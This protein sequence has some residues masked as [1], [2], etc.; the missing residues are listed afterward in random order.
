MAEILSEGVETIDLAPLAV[1]TRLVKLICV[2]GVDTKLVTVGQVLDLLVDAA[3]GSLDTLNELAAAIG[4][5]ANFA[6]TVIAALANRLR[7]DAAQTLTSDQQDRGRANLGISGRNLI[8]NGQGRVNQRGYVSGAATTGANQ[9][10]LDR[11]RV[12]TS[13][14]NLSFTG[15]DSRRVMTAPAGGAEQVV[16][17][18]AV[19]GGTYVLN[20]TG[21]A[22]ATV[23]G[24]ARAKGATFTLAAN[25]NVTIR[26]SGGTFSDVQLELAS[27]PTAY[28]RFSYARELVECQRY[29]LVG[30][31]TVR[32]QG[33]TSASDSPRIMVWFKSTMRAAPSLALADGTNVGFPAG[34]PSTEFLSADGFAAFKTASASGNSSFSFTYR[35]DAE[36]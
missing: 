35:A 21:T 7:V 23:N 13:G 12:V 4:D 28:E 25:T 2:A 5:D 26:L 1:A 9:Y 33:S 30:A 32:F 31:G 34:V 3:P 15:D 10:T 11:W 27:V 18:S 6:A 24:V 17:G 8:I 19:V 22:T 16:E 36:L 14:Q 29:F 20:W